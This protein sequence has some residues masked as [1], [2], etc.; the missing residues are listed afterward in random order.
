MVAGA[1]IGIDQ[2]TGHISIGY[3]PTVQ[4]VATSRLVLN[5]TDNGLALVGS[6]GCEV[7]ESLLFLINLVIL[8]YCSWIAVRAE[9]GMVEGDVN[10][11][12]LSYKVGRERR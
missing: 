9:R 8:V 7:M 3:L 2:E 1:G 5:V 12:L 6:R 4:P 10:L 11:G